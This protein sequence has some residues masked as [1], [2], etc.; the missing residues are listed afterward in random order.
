MATKIDWVVAL[1]NARGLRANVWNPFAGCTPVSEGCRHCWAATEAHMRRN[2]QKV[3]PFF[4][5]LT[6]VNDKNKPVFI[7]TVRE[8]TGQEMIKPLHTRHKTVYFL[9][10]FDPF[11][12]ALTNDQIDQIFAVMALSPQHLFLVLTKRPTR[13][14]DYLTTRERAIAEHAI[15]WSTF[16]CINAPSVRWP[17][18]VGRVLDYI[19]DGFVTWPLPNVW[20]GTSVEDQES[21]DQ[22]LQP[23]IETPAALRFLSAEPLLAGLDI[24]RD[25][26][27]ALD[28]V[29]A[30]GESGPGSRPTLPDWVRSLRDQC[31]DNNVPFYFKQWGDW[32]V[33]DNA[34]I[35]VGKHVSGRSID[36]CH[37]LDVPRKGLL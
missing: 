3:A 4:A 33:C 27:G 7:G 17:N 37:H 15:C 36:G 1:A 35:R 31:T 16:S 5:D 2:N 30:G 20:L 11:H 12:A 14:R 6:R 13:L 32:I 9:S 34:A 25:Q 23:L 22:R 29:I 8:T 26:L 19:P 28:W 18:G 21:A 10:R 24:N